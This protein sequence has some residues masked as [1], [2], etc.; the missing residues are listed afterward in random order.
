[1]LNDVFTPT[2][3]ELDWARRVVDAAEKAAQ[4]GAGIFKV[5]GQMIDL[6]LV[7]RA[8]NMLART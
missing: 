5:D 4:Q 1:M 7:L 3:A 8:Q 2:E 6:P